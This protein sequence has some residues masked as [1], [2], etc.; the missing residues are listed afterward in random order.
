MDRQHGRT[1][2]DRECAR[3]GLVIVR[4]RW[5]LKVSGWVVLEGAGGG[6]QQ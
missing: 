3:R 5:L 1:D 6:A 4:E 2:N